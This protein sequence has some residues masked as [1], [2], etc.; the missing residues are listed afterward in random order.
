MVVVSVRS[1][2][3]WVAVR[4]VEKIPVVCRMEVLKVIGDPLLFSEKINKGCAEPFNPKSVL[5]LKEFPSAYRVALVLDVRLPI[6]QDTA[7]AVELRGKS[8]TKY[9]PLLNARPPT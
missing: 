1:A 5:L 9:V 6:M 3:A 8:P 4:P 7:E 2:A